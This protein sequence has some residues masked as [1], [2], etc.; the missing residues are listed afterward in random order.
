LDNNEGSTGIAGSPTLTLY[1]FA[2]NIDA[3]G[4]TVGAL[5]VDTSAATLTGAMTVTNAVTLTAGTLN[6]GSATLKVGT[7]WS[8]SGTFTGNAG[9]VEFTG[10]GTVTPSAGST[11]AN[12]TKSTGG[13]TTLGGGVNG[14]R[15]VEG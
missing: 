5:T 2:S 11:F 14:D 10:T 9:T 6:G 7:G 4:A 8:G 13:T 12:V 3:D 1:G 15:S